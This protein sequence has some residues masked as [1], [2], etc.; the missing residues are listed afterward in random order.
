MERQFALEKILFGKPAAWKFYKTAPFVRVEP[1]SAISYEQVP[2]GVKASC[3][4]AYMD[5][6]HGVE[7]VYVGGIFPDC[8]KPLP[9]CHLLPWNRIVSGIPAACCQ[10]RQRE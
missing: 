6:C 1:V 9:R 8:F 3:A 7:H 5:A 10:G 2:D 4:F